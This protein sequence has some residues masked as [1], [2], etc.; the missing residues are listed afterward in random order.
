MDLVTA[1]CQALLLRRGRVN[2][3][4]HVLRGME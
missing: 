3:Y 1:N 2:T 4:C